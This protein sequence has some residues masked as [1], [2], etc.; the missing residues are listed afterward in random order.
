M[1][2]WF[3]MELNS[4]FAFQEALEVCDHVRNGHQF[5]AFTK[6]EFIAK[7]GQVYR[8]MGRA[9]A[10][11]D[12]EKALRSFEN[13]VRQY[14]EAMSFAIQSG[15][16]GSKN[17]AWLEDAFAELTIAANRH[18]RRAD[19]VDFVKA[20]VGGI[21]SLSPLVSQ[22]TRFI[23]A[24]ASDRRSQPGGIKSALVNLRARV[25]ARN[26][27]NLTVEDKAAIT[28]AIEAVL[29]QIS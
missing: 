24:T 3:Y 7:K 27:N 18:R 21:P 23:A 10:V 13:A 12:S 5:G 29:P 22:I 15:F 26:V 9:N 20:E 28:G 14:L 2:D 8:H 25:M 4:G 1:R 17:E 19:I 6:N 11:R 16:D